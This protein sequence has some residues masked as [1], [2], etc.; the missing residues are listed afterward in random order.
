M[1]TGG[2]VLAGT[3]VVGVDAVELGARPADDTG[4]GKDGGDPRRPKT[5]QAAPMPMAAARPRMVNSRPRVTVL[6]LFPLASGEEDG[7][8][9][10]ADEQKPTT[11]EQ[12]A[13]VA[14]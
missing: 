1:E 10:E 6:R 13:V 4:P 8:R 11:H 2:L 14:V 7:C 3:D 9:Q 12:E 5:R